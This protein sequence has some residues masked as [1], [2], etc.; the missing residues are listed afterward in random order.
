MLPLERRQAAGLR[1]SWKE[2]SPSSAAKIHVSLLLL[3]W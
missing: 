3:N 1:W 2:A